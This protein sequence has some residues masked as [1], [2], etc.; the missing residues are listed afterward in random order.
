MKVN[1]ILIQEETLQAALKRLMKKNGS[2]GSVVGNRTNDVLAV[3]RGSKKTD[4]VYTM[5]GESPMTS[6]LVKSVAASAA[7]ATV[8]STDASDEE[9]KV[10]RMPGGAKVL[11]LGQG[12]DITLVMTD[13]DYGQLVESKDV[14]D[15][16]SK[17]KDEQEQIDPKIVKKVQKKA[18]KTTN[19]D[20][21][22]H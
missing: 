7:Y 5:K 17:K 19:G 20:K 15:I 12:Q 11:V 18:P 21:I 22:P 2:L 13:N 1:E 9:I 14:K 8:D 16:Y 4:N 3:L 10:V 6:R